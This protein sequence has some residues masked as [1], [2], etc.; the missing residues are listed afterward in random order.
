MPLRYP[1]CEATTATVYD[2][3]EELRFAYRKTTQIAK[4]SALVITETIEEETAKIQ[5]ID[6]MEEVALAK[7]K[8]KI[9]KPA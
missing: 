5:P 4:P 1:A 9:G 2:K 3:Q 7:G 6:Q 8:L